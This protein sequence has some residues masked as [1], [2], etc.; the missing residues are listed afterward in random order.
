MKPEPVYLHVEAAERYVDE[1]LSGKAGAG[2]FERLACERHRRDLV[3]AA[4]GGPFVFDRV[5]AERVCKFIET[6]HHVKGEW[7]QRRETIRLEGWQCFVQVSIFG[8]VNRETGLRRFQTVYLEVARKNAKSTLLSG[9]GLYCLALDGEAGAEVYSAA[10]TKEQARK[11]F[12]PARKMAERNPDLRLRAGIHVQVHKILQPKTNSEFLP[13]ASQTNSLDGLSPSCALVDELHAHASREVWDVIG[14]G[15]GARD[16]PLKIAITTAGS[17]LA[18]VC[19]EERTDLEKIL[20]RIVEDDTV[21]GV[22]FAIDEEDDPFDERVWRKANPNLGVSVRLDFLRKES[23]KAQRT[24]TQRGE[25]L[26][27]HCCRWSA[28]GVSAFDLD[29]WRERVDADLRLE[30]MAGLAG[31]TIGMD[32]SKNNDLTSVVVMGW[33]GA[34]LVLWDEHWA[35]EDA[36]GAPGNE[37]LKEWAAACWLHTCPG[38]LIDLEQVETRVCEIIDAVRPG[39][40]T[41]D[42]MYLMQMAAR[43][44]KRYGTAPAVIEQK[45]TTMALDP[46]LR[47]LQGLVLDRHVVSRGNPVMDWMVSNARAKPSHGGGSEFLKLFKQMPSAKIDGVQALLTGLARMEAPEE[48]APPSV[49]ETRGVLVL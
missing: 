47:T 27:K 39:E 12:D 16:Q 18:G 40:V 36:V 34:D 22:I 32:G 17:N 19:Y 44:E 35:T 2:L 14:S 13:L 28:A 4:A 24:P 6:L 41:Y 30:D 11:V 42:P 25:F 15:Q 43:L 20:R 45:Q 49:Y 21:F 8:W 31:L 3:R 7:A 26:R 33:D 29:C 23:A 37:H 48:A 10:T 1:V 9:T 46:A 5:K 38:A